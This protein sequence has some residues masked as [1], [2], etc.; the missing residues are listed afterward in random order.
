MKE[1]AN[2]FKENPFVKSSKYKKDVLVGF[3]LITFIYGLI[4]SQIHYN[5]IWNKLLSVHMP[6]DIKSAGEV[7]CK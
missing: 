5:H 6:L 4:C 7:E 1:T 2:L 3:H